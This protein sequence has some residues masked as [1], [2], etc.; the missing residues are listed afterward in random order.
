M[1]EFRAFDQRVELSGGHLKAIIQA[2]PEGTQSIADNILSAKG[3]QDPQ[4]GAWYSLQTVLDVMKD[5]YETFYPGM[6]TRMGY[7]VAQLVELPPHWDSVDIAFKELGVGYQMNHRGGEIGSYSFD[8]LGTE[9]GL[10]RGKMTVKTHWPCEYELGLLQGMGDRF[11]RG[12]SEVLVRKDY[13]A[14]CRKRGGDSCTF[15]V[16]WT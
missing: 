15:L 13:N 4:P 6:L 11:K 2:F 1:Q 7:Q 16:S 3:L 14:T 9:G 5:L 12:P 8:D 10:R